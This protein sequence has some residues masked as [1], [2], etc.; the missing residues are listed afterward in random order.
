MTMGKAAQA[1]I[2]VVAT[3]L[4]TLALATPLQAQDDVMNGGPPT[5]SDDIL[6][7]T[8]SCVAAYDNEI[9]AGDAKGDPAVVQARTAAVE[10]YAEVSGESS[11]DIAADIRQADLDLSKELDGDGDSLEDAAATCD[12]AF[13]DDTSEGSDADTTL[14]A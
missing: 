6:D 2:A 12:A 5:A 8:L 1:K 9:A 11:S 13:M 3:A 14:I 4:L 7:G 10:L